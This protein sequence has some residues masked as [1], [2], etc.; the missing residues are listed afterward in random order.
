MAFEPPFRVGAPSERPAAD[1]TTHPSVRPRSIVATSALR[2]RRNAFGSDMHDV[3]ACHADG[4]YR[5]Q[6][7]GGPGSSRNAGAL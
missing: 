6:P 4:C 1:A 3:S 7:S 2:A 5:W